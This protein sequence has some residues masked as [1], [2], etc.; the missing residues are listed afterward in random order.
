MDPLTE[1]EWESCMIAPGRDAEVEQYVRTTMGMVPPLAPYFYGRPWI[2]RTIVGFDGSQLALR[3]VDD[4]FARL[5][6]LVVAQENS[7]RFCYAASRALL[8][9]F[10][11]RDV[12]IQRIEQNLQTAELSTRVRVGLEF[13]RRVA[14]ANPLPGSS[15]RRKLLDA[16]YSPDGIGELAFL[17]GVNV[18]YNRLATLPAVPTESV[19]RMARSWWL[20]I[21]RPILARLMRPRRPTPAAEGAAYDGPFAYLV[22]ALGALPIGATLADRLRDAWTSPTL[23]QRTKA[24]LFAVVARGLD[25]PISERE[26]ERVLASE[27]VPPAET[28]SILEHLASPAL[29]AV[30]ALLVPY[31]RET[32]WFRP[33]QIQRR[34]RTLHASLPAEQLLEAIG[35]V[36]LAN[37]VCR[38]NVVLAGG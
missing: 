2:V 25:C 20:P 22:N 9:L 28:T 15:E 21:L 11:Y 5:I 26:A 12:R 27:G 23:S 16:G 30:E 19:E 17:A 24:L 38:M 32:I 33:A 8:K 37:A 4:D 35:I 18:F 34:T 13:A 7:C 36:S 3:H 29:D 31:A 14:R 6:G 10:G 1:I